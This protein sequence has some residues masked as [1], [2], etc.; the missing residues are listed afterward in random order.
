MIMAQVTGEQGDQVYSVILLLLLV[1]V[2]VLVMVVPVVLVL[3]L[4]LVVVVTHDSRNG[5]DA[6]A[7]PGPQPCGV[8]EQVQ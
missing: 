2:V 5:R 6:G 8:Q 7:C 1:V 3:V 4:V